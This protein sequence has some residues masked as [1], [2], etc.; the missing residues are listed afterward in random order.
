MN[1]YKAP[2]DSVIKL[3]VKKYRRRTSGIEPGANAL[4]S[5]TMQRA[6]AIASPMAY[7]F[8]LDSRLVLLVP[9]SETDAP[10]YY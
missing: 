1:F 5:T 7:F 10:F 3:G 8:R 9:I 6:Y 2:A 4:I